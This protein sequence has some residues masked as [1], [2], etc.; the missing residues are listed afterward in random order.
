M[1]RDLTVSIALIVFCLLW[2]IGILIL[3][4]VLIVLALIGAII[5]TILAA[6]WRL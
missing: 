4:K 3:S 5:A 1:K 2:V 6:V